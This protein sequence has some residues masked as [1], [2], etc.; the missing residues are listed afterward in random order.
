MQGLCLCPDGITTSNQVEPRVSI[1]SKGMRKQT[2][3]MFKMCPAY[4]C[5]TV[6]DTESFIVIKCCFTNL[7][8]PL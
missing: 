2:N 4:K 7:C 6:L 8:N 3:S 5:V 1:I